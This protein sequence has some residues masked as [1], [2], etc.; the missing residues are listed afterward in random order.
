[1]CGKARPFDWYGQISV[2][3]DRY[4]GMPW[5]VYIRIFW[6]T[7]RKLGR[8]AGLSY[9][10]ELLVESVL[11]R[12]DKHGAESFLLDWQS[13]LTRKRP[14][15]REEVVIKMFVPGQHYHVLGKRFDTHGAAW[16]YAES[17][18]YEVAGFKKYVVSL[19]GD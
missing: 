16:D 7:Q 18:G 15:P 4:D 3:F 2:P 1:M 13:P 9:I 19:G 14:P 10:Q 12:G 17:E 5:P 6:D 8:T 11:A